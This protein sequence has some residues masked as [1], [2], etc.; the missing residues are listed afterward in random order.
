MFEE[1]FQQGGFALLCDLMVGDDSQI[2]QM[3]GFE[4]PGFGKLGLSEAVEQIGRVRIGALL[5]VVEADIDDD[6]Q[7]VML[8]LQMLTHQGNGVFQL[9]KSQKGVGGGLMLLYSQPHGHHDCELIK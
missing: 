8:L 5:A 6:G 9:A 1:V 2:N 7:F 3:E 4:H